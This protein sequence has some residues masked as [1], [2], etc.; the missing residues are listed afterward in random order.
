VDELP[1]YRKALLSA[2]GCDIEQLRHIASGVPVQGWFRSGETGEGTPHYQLFHLWIVDNREFSVQVNR[3]MGQEIPLLEIFD[4]DSWTASHYSP[5]T[6]IH[7][8]IDSFSASRLAEIAMLEAA[9]PADWSRL[10]RHPRWGVRT[11]QW[12]VERQHEVT[13]HDLHE[14]GRCLDV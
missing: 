9:S 5:D 7:L 1:A 10:S 12:W 14:L 4:A 6:P 13:L 8:M 11:L 2:L 3:I